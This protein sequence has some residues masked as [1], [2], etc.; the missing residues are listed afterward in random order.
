MAVL[1]LV[2]GIAVGRA[3]SHQH[4]SAAASSEPSLVKAPPPVVPS[5]T[6]QPLQVGKR[7]VLDVLVRAQ[8][9]WVLHADRLTG[10]GIASGRDRTVSLPAIKLS[11][12]SAALRLVPDVT[13]CPAVGCPGGR[14]EWAGDRVRPVEPDP[15]A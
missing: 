3:G 9:T 10:L 13:Q 4:P 2:A 1:V 12:P 6:G 7:A 11:S 14:A 5:S 8:H 15:A